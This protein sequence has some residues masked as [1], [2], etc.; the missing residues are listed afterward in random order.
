MI[1][2]VAVLVAIV[3]VVAM[4][5][6]PVFADT[7]YAGSFDEDFGVVI[8]DGVPVS[9]EY[10]LSLVFHPDFGYS[11]QTVPVTLTATEIEEDGY[12]MPVVVGSFQ[13]DYSG[14]VRTA[15]MLI[16]VAIPFD[17]DNPDQLYNVVQFTSSDLGLP[18]V[19]FTLSP[20]P[21][22]PVSP[23]ESVFDIFSS[24]GSWLSTSLSEFI[25]LFYNVDSGFTLLGI[26]C[27]IPIGVSICFLIFIL[28]VNFFKFR[29]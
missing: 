26:L 14:E 8:C 17:Q 5:A 1:K 20:A 2:R 10:E 21:V 22:D 11:D 24:I 4:L 9:G 18:V 13:L 7:L 29:S 19:S 3:A 6:L 25:S 12:A 23:I 27:V 15:E 16:L 28:I